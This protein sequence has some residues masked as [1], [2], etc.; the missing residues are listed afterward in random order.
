[1]TDVRELWRTAP[2]AV[3]GFAS[4]A[5][6]LLSPM[7]FW[8][9]GSALWVTTSAS[10]VKTRLLRRSSACAVYVP[11]SERDG[12]GLVARGAARVY[13]LADPVEL[14]LHGPPISGALTALAAKYS[15][16]V[17]GYTRDLGSLPARWLPQR[18]VLM[19]I[20][21]RDERTVL[22][23]PPP[24]G[25]VPALPSVVPSDVRRTLSGHRKLAVAVAG[26]TGVRVLPGVWGAGFALQVAGPALPDETPVAAML[27]AETGTR[28]SR[29]VG[30]VLRGRFAEGRL[31][32]ERVTWWRG[33][34]IN[35]ETLAPLPV[36]GI[37]LPE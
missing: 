35:T 23:P 4:S 37:E 22:T 15:S 19:R 25:M 9:D 16:T 29:V 8:H 5:G 31:R 17:L 27:D 10:A 1:M 3:L 6:P 21:L 18:R 11:A 7:A 12:L 2:R 13:G 36:G 20:W 32:P 26:P 33:F 28:P 30:A 24:V 14:A 34:E